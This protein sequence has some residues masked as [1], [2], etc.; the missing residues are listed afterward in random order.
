MVSTCVATQCGEDLTGPSCHHQRPPGV[1]SHVPFLSCYQNPLPCS[2]GDSFGRCKSWWKDISM[3]T[4]F[5][6]CFF[7]W[8]IA[9]L[10]QASISIRWL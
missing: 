8:R 9:D 7:E 5:H 4:V 1:L 10:R 3:L 2:H 6:F